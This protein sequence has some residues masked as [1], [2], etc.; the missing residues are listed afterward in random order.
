MIKLWRLRKGVSNRVVQEMYFKDLKDFYHQ[1]GV[2][3]ET[4]SQ[5][6]W[7]M[8]D[9]PI[10]TATKKFLT[11]VK[12]ISGEVGIIVHNRI[13]PTKFSG[14]KIGKYV[15]VTNRTFLDLF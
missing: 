10:I 3:K 5:F 13:Y 1:L 9:S 2:D 7:L 15:Y 4:C 11:E 6:F 8:D 14:Y 12:K